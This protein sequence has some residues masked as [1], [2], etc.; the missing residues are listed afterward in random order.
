MRSFTSAASAYFADA[1]K[2][3]DRLYQQLLREGWTPYVSFE[4]T[5]VASPLHGERP[6]ND[7]IGKTYLK[8]TLSA[9]FAP[10]DER[11]DDPAVRLRIGN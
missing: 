6:V 2:L 11:C 10:L 3:Y 4:S 8:R 5:T 7:L 1:Q 9:P